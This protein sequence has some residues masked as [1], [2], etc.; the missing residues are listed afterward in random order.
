MSKSK[1]GGA[2]P[3]A[4]RKKRSVKHAGPVATAEQRIADQLPSLIENM[5][6]LAHG[7]YQRVEEEWTPLADESD[8][9][10]TSTPSGP[11]PLVMTKR[12][13]SWAEPDRSAN[14]YLIDRILG[15]PRQSV[16]V[17]GD[18]RR[19]VPITIDALI[20]KVYGDSEATAS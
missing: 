9:G 19:P 20:C 6:K 7:G 13:V 17:G 4:G 12:K 1:R 2:R 5:L 11:H 3:G 10:E 15:R 16:E 8:D 18:G 14:V